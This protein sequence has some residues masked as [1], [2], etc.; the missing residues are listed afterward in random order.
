MQAHLAA[1]IKEKFNK[2]LQTSKNK[3]KSVEAGREYVEAY[4][5]YTHFVKNIHDAIMKT[6]AHHGTG[7]KVD[8]GY[9]ES[10]GHK[11]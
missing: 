11:D 7:S 1:Q 10:L 3:D 2:A 8:K 6:G 9:S 5:Q 4:V